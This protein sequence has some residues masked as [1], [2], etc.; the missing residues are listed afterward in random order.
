MTEFLDDD[1][2]FCELLIFTETVADDHGCL[3]FILLATPW[4]LWF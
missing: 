1:E 2:E 4:W 3:L